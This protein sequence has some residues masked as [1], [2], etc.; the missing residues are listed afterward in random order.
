MSKL[1]DYANKYRHVAVERH[2]GILEVSFHTN[3]GPFIFSGRAHRELGDAF[4]DIARDRNN[5]V[6]II[7]GT[8]DS[9]CAALDLPANPAR[10][11]ADVWTIIY[12]QGKR[13]LMNLLE[14]G[15][16]VIGAVNGPAL[17]H[18]ELPGQNTL[19]R[20][21]VGNAPFG[22]PMPGGCSASASPRPPGCGRGQ[23][24]WLLLFV[25]TD[26][27]RGCG[28]GRPSQSII[29]KTTSDFVSLCG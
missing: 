27:T 13:M 1:D 7:T 10:T 2:D 21:R 18:A 8:G 12:T 17:V 24:A 6:V 11:T 23:A 16:P 5:E 26:V 25:A 3:G 20:E 14:I 29:L 22:S 15:V 9:F 28:C 4:I 19:V